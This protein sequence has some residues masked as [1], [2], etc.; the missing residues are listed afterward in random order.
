MHS[1]S[2]PLGVRT[3]SRFVM[4]RSRHVRIDQPRVHEVAQQIINTPSLPQATSWSADHLGELELTD[5]EI[6][7][8]VLVLDALNF[9]FWGDP[10]WKVAWEG[11]SHN[12]YQALVYA[13]RRALLEGYPITDATYLATIPAADVAHILRG[14]SVIPLFSSRVHNLRE[15]GQSLVREHNGRFLDCVRQAENSGPELLRRVISLFPSFIDVRTCD[16]RTIPFYKRAQILVGDLS[17]AF[18]SRGEVLFDDLSFLTA[19]ADYKVPQV[20][21]QLGVLRYS[22]E[23]EQKL[24]RREHIPAGDPFEVEIRAATIIAVDN[25]TLSTIV[26]EIPVPSAVVDWYL[27]N[28]GRH[29][30]FERLPYH[31][32][33]TI[34]Y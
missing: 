6:A 13:L 17:A 1:L 22:S 20:L 27:W 21:H 23:L 4:D 7:N 33:P 29:W 18:E 14:E 31:R 8:F 25:I 9:Y 11:T 5:D 26:R 2:D 19:F 30:D 3:A 15:A 12:G 32:T 24:I 28:L 34:A 10:R 16:G